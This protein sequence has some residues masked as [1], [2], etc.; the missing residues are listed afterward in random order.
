VGGDDGLH[1]Q[2]SGRT[3]AGQLADEGL[4][5]GQQQHR[6][7]APL[8]ADGRAGSATQALPARALKV[9]REDL[10]VILETEQPPVAVVLLGGGVRSAEVWPTDVAYEEAGS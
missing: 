3:R 5:R 10:H 9:R 4:L 2:R 6:V 1:V 8:E 7:E